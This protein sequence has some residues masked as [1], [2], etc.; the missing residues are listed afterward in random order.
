MISIDRL[1]FR[2]PHS[3]F[4]LQVDSLQIERGEKVAFVGPSGSGKTTLLKLIAGIA[5]PDS[6]SLRVEDTDVARLAD[7]QRRNFRIARIGQ[8]FQQFELLP[9]LR[10]RE[11]I[12]LPFLINQTLAWTS[13]KARDLETLANRLGLA[14]KLQRFPSQLSQGEQQRVAIA[15]ALIHSPPLLLA[16]EPTGNLDPTN[17][18]NTLRLLFEQ[19]E[20][21]GATLIVVTHDTGILDGFT[22]VIDFSQFQK[23]AG[24]AAPAAAGGER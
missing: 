4:T 8:V 19:I 2:Y 20:S 6:G 23:S 13:S 17:K 11:N 24:L 18:Q 7:A 15:R 3:P 5:L 14:D 21:H 12:R 16:D 9:Y 10:V 1:S 22:R